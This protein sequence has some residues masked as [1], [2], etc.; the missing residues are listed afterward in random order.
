MKAE[1]CFEY[2]TNILGHIVSWFTWSEFSHAFLKVG[3]QIYEADP[4]HGV[5]IIPYDERN[6]ESIEIDINENVLKFIEERI[7][8]RYDYSAIV[9]FILRR[10]DWHNERAWFCSELIASALEYSDLKITSRKTNRIAPDDLYHA[11]L[12][13]KRYN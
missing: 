4:F 8:V 10:D 7:G 3:N 13:Y 5:R 9:G 6:Y 2:P 11:A 12:K 1:L